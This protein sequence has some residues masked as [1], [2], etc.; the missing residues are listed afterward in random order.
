MMT[1]PGHIYINW[2]SGPEDIS[3]KA[4]KG[5]T[6]NSNFN[7]G[8]ITYNKNKKLFTSG[9]TITVT[10]SQGGVYYVIIAGIT[11][12]RIR[13]SPTDNPSAEETPSE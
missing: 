2:D 13:L 12:G 7:G 6:Y 10:D 9:G 5:C 11:E 1:A 8:K 3:F 4:S